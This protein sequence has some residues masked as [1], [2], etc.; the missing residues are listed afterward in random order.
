[1]AKK[2]LLDVLEQTIGKYVRNLD[3]ESLN[4]AVWSGKIELNSL[5]LDV[6]AVNAELD[7]Q[8]AEA[9]NLAIP[10][11]VVSGQFGN[12]TIDVPWANLMSKSV[13]LRASSLSISVEPYNRTESADFLSAV[14]ES[15]AI[16]AKKVIQHRIQSIKQA[17][18]FRRRKNALRELAEQDLQSTT[19]TMN[20]QSN[21]SSSSFSARLIRRIIENFQI[22]IQGVHV[23]INGS[24]GSAGVVLKS[25]QLVTTDKNG[26]RTF[27]DRTQPS[28]EAKEN[29]FLHK[30]LSII[31]LGVYI[32]DKTE[33]TKLPSIGETEDENDND[34]IDEHSYILAPLSFDASLRQADSSMC[35]DFPKYLL[36]SELNALSVLLSR[37]QIEL[38]GAIERQI[39]PSQNVARPIFPEYR[40]LERVSS[41]TAVDWWKYAVRCIGR[42]S[43]RRSWVEFFLAFQKRKRYITL[44]KRSAHSVLCT[45]LQPLQEDEETE[46]AAIELDRS[47]SVEG[48]MY[49]RNISDAQAKKEMEK[50]VKQLDS[51]K[52]AKSSS[53]FTSLFGSTTTSAELTIENEPPITLTTEEMKELEG[54]DQSVES[55]LTIDSQL[56]DISF[57]LGSFRIHLSSYGKRQLA[58]LDMGRVFASFNANAN[59]SFTFDAGITSLTI[60][61]KVTP[62]SFF[63]YILRNQESLFVEN[64]QNINQ[65]LLSASGGEALRIQMEKSKDQHQSLRIHLSTFEAIASPIFLRELKRFTS[66]TVS[67][68]SQIDN[69]VLAQSMSGSV[70]LFYDASDGGFPLNDDNNCLEP[71]E[72]G[73]DGHAKVDSDGQAIKGDI[74]QKMIEAWKTKKETKA[75]WT[76]DCDLRAPIV[77]IPESCVDP[78]ANVLAFDLGNLKFNYGKMDTNNG[79]VAK[80]F[81]DNPRGDGNPLDLILDTGYMGI[82]SLSFMVGKVASWKNLTKRHD[83]SACSEDEEAV[84]EPIM[85]NLNF[86]VETRV[87]EDIP[88]VCILGVLPVISFRLSCDQ[89]SRILTVSNVWTT[90]LNELAP[91]TNSGGESETLQDKASSQELV[92]DL[93]NSEANPDIAEATGFNDVDGK[94]KTPQFTKFYADVRLQRLSVKVFTASK[95]GLDA[96]LISVVASTSVNSNG[97]SI[98]RLCMGWFWLLDQLVHDSPRIERLIVHSSLPSVSE[99]SSPEKRYNFLEKL[100]KLGVF[101]EDF[102]GSAELADMIY[103]QRSVEKSFGSQDPFCFDKLDGEDYNVDVIVDAVFSSLHINWNPP[104]VK[105]VVAFLGEFASALSSKNEKGELLVAE[106]ETTQKK[107]RNSETSYKTVDRKKNRASTGDTML[108]ARMD[109]LHLIL[110]SAIDDLPLFTLSMSRT[111]FCMVSGDESSRR[112]TIHLGELKVAS[113]EMGRTDPLY[114]NV[115]GLSSSTSESLLS[116]SYFSGRKAIAVVS[117]NDTSIKD[118]ESVGIIELS[119]MRMVYIQAQVLSLV[120]YFT[121]GILGALASQAASSAVQVATEIAM[122]TDSKTKFCVKASRFEFILPIAAYRKE[123]ISLQLGKLIV[124]YIMTVQTGGKA[125]ISLMNVT[126]QNSE[127]FFMLDVPIGMDI[128]VVI[129]LDGIGNK[130]DQAMRVKVAIS[131]S[132]FKISKRQYSQIMDMLSENIGE[133]DLFLRNEKSQALFSVENHVTEP[134][135]NSNETA[136]V[137]N[138][139]S[140]AGVQIIDNPRWI[141][142]Q[143]E[144]KS[145]SLQ[146]CGEDEDDPIILISAVEAFVE[147]NMYSDQGKKRTVVTLKDLFCEDQRLEALTRQHRSI[148]YQA[149]DPEGHKQTSQDAFV[150]SYSTDISEKLSTVEITI[151]KPRFVLIPDAIYEVLDFLSQPKP[152]KEADKKLQKPRLEELTEVVELSATESNLGIETA[153]V[154]KSS[155][156]V[157]TMLI[158]VKTSNC[159]VIFVDLGTAGPNTV[160]PKMSMSSGNRSV[161]ETIV[162]GGIFNANLKMTARDSDSITVGMESEFHGDDIEVYTAFG[163]DLSSSIQILDPTNFALF[164]ESKAESET[165]K[166]VD[167]RCAIISPVDITISM[168]NVALANAIS[169]SLSLL[170]ENDT[171]EGNNDNIGM[172]LDS[173][174]THR[175]DLL[176]AALENDGADDSE[177]GIEVTPDGLEEDN[178]KTE[179]AAHAPTVTSQSSY[180]LTTSDIRVTIVNDLQ[181][182]DEALLR[183]ST[184]N[185]ITSAQVLEGAR[186]KPFLPCFTAFDFTVHTSFLADYFDASTNSWKVLLVK[187]WELSLRGRRGPSERL[188]SNLPYTTF[189]VESL[190]CHVSFSEQFLMSLASANRMWAIYTA[191]STSSMSIVDQSSAISKGMRKSIAASAARS[192]VAALPYAVENRTGSDI[193]ILINGVR[194]EKRLCSEGSIEY[195]RFEP[196]VGS[197]GTGGKRLYGQD[198]NFEKSVVL[199]ITNSEIKL[200]HLDSLLGK[201]KTSHKLENGLIVTTEVVKDGKTI[202]STTLTR[203]KFNPK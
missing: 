181:G 64:D 13:V 57:I 38:A 59:G 110:N 92:A 19:K 53:I 141:F 184:R 42:L 81:Q 80:W 147:L 49:W 173:T 32:D 99:D 161:A 51:K 22:E 83:T 137:T 43:G 197:H 113:P 127:D 179:E 112:L 2:A 6:D 55:E 134:T 143:I 169:A 29:L 119:P 153:V 28:V 191:A 66:P 36:K 106:A 121:A 40:P 74:S 12:F 192:F 63:P 167:L 17:D 128:D 155:E 163:H 111:S 196:P 24:E 178:I 194:E 186:I 150:I 76:V 52:A 174:A 138:E 69:A 87:Q 94:E 200:P 158:S 98:A 96:H 90:F 136:L 84:I 11:R 70:D 1:M 109:G 47:I 8:A 151:G 129:P 67:P 108:R 25:L 125:A 122:P 165:V 166:H 71:I 18:D 133:L 77:F 104:A 31:G 103:K 88:R 33:G 195:F 190:S 91:T 115:L 26:K 198:V 7:R 120:E 114:R 156:P 46:I 148:V 185:F 130:D 37:R 144:M 95:G 142:M 126:M 14:F 164:Y 132:P 68:S 201:A 107:R 131:N 35:I 139:V 199:F 203:P 117:Q 93:S 154:M 149:R 20:E 202:V 75:T 4:V 62:N 171:P 102:E 27:V 160:N 48:I 157:S 175:I 16:R 21:Q 140:H 34:G 44:Y 97:T 78:K 162:L 41:R 170:M 3:A 135:V 23:T 58:A 105:R 82:S 60:D 54:V 146:M 176:A 168:K 72:W 65:N 85:L 172:G 123:Y 180:K 100:E 73:H 189:D 30:A 79:K 152:V 183:L 182:L 61:D 193:E 118:F 159:S 101:N 188:P 39:R 15:E 177:L 9:P 116:V 10:F 124:E 86:G 56:Y 145:L 89:L 45:W 50:H 5:E 187:P